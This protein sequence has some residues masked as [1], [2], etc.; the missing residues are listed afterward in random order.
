MNAK[1]PFIDS[2]NLSMMNGLR[3]VEP[4]LMHKDRATKFEEL[5]FVGRKSVILD[6]GCV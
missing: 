5:V 4:Y 3:I 1:F 2:S 6:N